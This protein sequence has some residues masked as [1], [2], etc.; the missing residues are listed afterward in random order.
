MILD[1][2]HW[3][4]AAFVVAAMWAALQF[5]G[6]QIEPQDEVERSTSAVCRTAPK[7]VSKSGLCVE[8]RTG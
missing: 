1:V 4:G 8:I 5:E 6:E 3:I 2:L 7:P